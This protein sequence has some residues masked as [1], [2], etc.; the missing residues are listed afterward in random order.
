MTTTDLKMDGVSPKARKYVDLS[1]FGFSGK[2]AVIDL[3][4]E[5][6]DFSVPNSAFEFCLLRIQG[7]ILD[8]ED[9]LYN[10]WSPIRSDAAIRR[11]KRLV[12]R[13][14][15][16]ADWRSPSSWLAGAGWNYDHYFNHR[17]ISL[18]N[19]YVRNLVQTAW[20]TDWPFPKTEVNGIELLFRRAMNKLGIQRAYDF[21]VHLSLPEDF[22]FL[23]RE[24]LNSILS[25]NVEDHIE[26]IVLHNAFEP[27]NPERCM[28][29]FE[30][31]YC[32]VIDR[33]PRD[34][35]VEQ[36]SYRPM[37]VGARDFVTRHQI[38]RRARSR[39][40]STNENILQLRFED[41]VNDYDHT[42]GKI[43]DYLGETHSVHIQPRRYFDPH[44]S[45]NNIGIW[46]RYNNSEE[47]DFIQGELSEYCYD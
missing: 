26:T 7:G 34:A 16:K 21:D 4:R 36:L 14:G 12:T 22:V 40:Q 38:Y 43:I 37:A 29:Y 17:F 32:I 41:L 44:I 28:K 1:G 25:S 5:F 18:S 9:A 39:F 10:D 15:A 23:T 47:I 33:D 30:S 35:Y 24:Y 31:P 11:F 46:R 27:F 13:L 20:T 42:V 8:L 19:N 3:L 2:S 6:R 45:K